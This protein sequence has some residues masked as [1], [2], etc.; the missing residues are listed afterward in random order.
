MEKAKTQA[1]ILQFWRQLT[2]SLFDLVDNLASS[3][4]SPL[5][6]VDRRKIMDAPIPLIEVAR[7]RKHVIGDR[8]RLPKLAV[9]R[10]VMR[11]AA[12]WSYPPW[13]DGLRQPHPG[14]GK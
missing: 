14:P 3:I 2:I 12:P 4:V 8:S 10:E 13:T 9:N 1:V 6:R 7:A 11:E 5:Q